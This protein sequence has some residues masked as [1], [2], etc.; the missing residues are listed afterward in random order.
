MGRRTNL[1]MIALVFIWGGAWKAAS[2]EI[3]PGVS[4]AQQPETLP[5]PTQGYEA[6]LVG[7]FHGLEENEEFQIQ[8][9][10]QLHRVSSL[11]DVAI[12]E[13]AVYENDAQA[14]V[15]GK[16]DVLPSPL[17]L[18]AGVL[19]GIRRL[20]TELSKDARICIHLIDI[21]SPAVAHLAAIKKRLRANHVSIPTKSAIKKHGLEAAAQLKLVA[22]DSATLSELRTVELSIL[23][24]QQGLEV[25]IGSPKGSPYLDSREQAIADN[26]VD[27]I[28]IRRTP[29]LL[30][31][32]GSRPRIKDSQKRRWFQQRSTLH[33]HGPPPG[34]IWHQSLF[35]GDI[36]SFGPVLLERPRKRASLDSY[37]RTPGLR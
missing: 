10:R 32:Y 23:A 19:Y 11:R 34:A 27:L 4:A 16:S 12:E 30:V 25:D 6:Y 37:R 13:D 9:L 29:S 24:Y 20:N 2:Q 36:P 26:I 15:D 21:D 22:T 17:C 8:Y 31:L 3:R 5:L 7:E 1:I 18:R 14:F 35:S 28:R 33:A